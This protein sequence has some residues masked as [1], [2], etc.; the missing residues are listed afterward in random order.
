MSGPGELILGVETSCDDTGVALVTRGGE[1]L[2][3][4]VASQGLLHDRYG[5]VVPEVAARRHLEVLDA[6]AADAFERAG[7]EREEVGLV[8][9]TQGPGLIGALLVGLSWAKAFAAARELPLAAVDHLHGHAVASTLEA[10]PITPPF[11]VLVASGGHTFLA[12][13]EDPAAYRVLGETL[14]DAAGEAF[15][16][17]ARL[18]GLPYPGGPALDRLARQGDAAAFDFPRARPGRLDFSF[19]G[20]KTALLYKVRELGP[21][22]EQRRAD[23]AASYQRA[24]VDALLARLRD[25]VEE[26]GIERVA[27]GGGVA[28]NS[29]LRERA[30]ELADELGVRL[31]IPP[32]ALCTDNAAMIAG[33]A[34]FLEPLAFPDYLVLDAKARLERQVLA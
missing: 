24:I 21:E 6:V 26:T 34:R 17:G 1:I 31:W 18:L 7:A 20:L 33:A 10:E 4:V 12:L 5:G 30:R 23:L 27:L 16:K 13:V 2:A 28:A 14:D 22:A 11:L 32:I 15:D 25:A 19:S 29:E 9:V 8:A 3:N